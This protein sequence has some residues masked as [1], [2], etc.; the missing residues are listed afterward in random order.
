MC[1]AAIPLYVAFNQS[2]AGHYDAVLLKKVPSNVITYKSD[3]G[4]RCTCGRS[5]K[6][7]FTMQRCTVM[8]H[9]YTT[10]VR[11]PC[12][13]GGR[14]CTPLCQCSNCGNPHGVKPKITHKKTRERR[15][16]AWNNV[17]I[18]SA[19]YAQLEKEKVVT[20]RRTQLEYLL[21]CQIL[22]LLRRN[23]MNRDSNVVHKIYTACLELCHLKDI[24]LPLGQKTCNEISS[25]I[26][27]Y[28]KHKQVFECTCIAQLKITHEH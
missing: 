19:L 24:S 18:K 4:T 3:P 21:V 26:A 7:C 20:G 10:S 1:R 28:D 13:L 15:R 23:Q 14:G 22:S 27:E 11:C 2:G 5:G 16:H 17:P 12:H 6:H 9:K 8:E 25:I